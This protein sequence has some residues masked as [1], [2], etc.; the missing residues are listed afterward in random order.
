MVERIG[1][2]GRFMNTFDSVL[3]DSADSY[4]Q[5]RN[6]YLQK[7][8]FEL[9]GDEAGSDPYLDSYG[10]SNPYEDPYSE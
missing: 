2:R 10:A 4:A 7:R 1:V 3:Y 8:R 6:A 9:G 5:T